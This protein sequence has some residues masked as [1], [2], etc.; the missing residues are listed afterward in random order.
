MRRDPRPRSF[1]AGALNMPRR[2]TNSVGVHARYRPLNPEQRADHVETLF[3]LGRLV[4]GLPTA[5][6]LRRTFIVLSLTN[7]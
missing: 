5:R 7:D 6:K 4:V 2:W 1:G 3:M